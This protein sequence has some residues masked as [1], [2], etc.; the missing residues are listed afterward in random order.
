LSLANTA[1]IS[2]A[3]IGP[4]NAGKIVI[5]ASD[6]VAL[7]ENSII[8]AGAVSFSR[9]NIDFVRQ[10]V[11]RQLFGSVDLNTILDSVE[12]SGLPSNVG[13]ANDIEITARSIRL[14]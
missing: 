4:G 10:Q 13:R 1:G 7:S 6:N 3:T 14:N 9:D 12:Q 5:N 8:Q 11:I 2:T